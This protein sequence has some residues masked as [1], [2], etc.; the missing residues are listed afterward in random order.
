MARVRR[1]G[2]SPPQANPPRTVAAPDSLFWSL[3]MSRVYAELS[4]SL[5]GDVAGGA[6]TPASRSASG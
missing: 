4:M 6:I 3:A 2:W 5:D 1:A